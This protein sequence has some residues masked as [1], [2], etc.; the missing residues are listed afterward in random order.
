MICC[1]IHLTRQAYGNNTWSH[2][3]LASCLITANVLN[4]VGKTILIIL[5]ILT[6]T[7]FPLCAD[8]ILSSNIYYPHHFDL[9]RLTSTLN[10]CLT[11]LTNWALRAHALV[12][13]RSHFITGRIT[14]TPT[15]ISPKHN[16]SQVIL[17]YLFLYI[18]RGVG[19]AFSIWTYCNK[20]RFAAD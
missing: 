7:L 20:I 6:V 17:I 12:V 19:T 13:E 9:I 10:L 3:K 5:M 8:Y 4:I 1:C 2:L 16:F 15:L 11:P 18:L 14:Y